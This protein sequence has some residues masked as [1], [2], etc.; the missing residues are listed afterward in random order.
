MKGPGLVFFAAVLAAGC[1]VQT[2]V[3]RP[4]PDD[5]ADIAPARTPPRATAP[6]PT[7]APAPAP[8][9]PSSPPTGEVSSSDRPLSAD[10]I[11]PEPIAA[12]VSIAAEPCKSAG[13]HLSLLVPAAQDL[14][15]SFHGAVGGIEIRRTAASGT[16]GWKNAIRKGGVLEVDIWA[17]GSGILVGAL[18]SESCKGG[19]PADV[20]F[21][22][23]AHYRRSLVR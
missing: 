13:R 4:V 21:E 8:R 14:D 17:R 7:P 22:F 15:D 6:D 11:L 12:P 23:L 16:G 3:S 1:A 5:A 2:N 20:R 10:G 18:G 19:G 9:S